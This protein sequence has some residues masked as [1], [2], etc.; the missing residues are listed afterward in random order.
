VVPGIL[1]AGLVIG[2]LAGLGADLGRPAVARIQL[3]GASDRAAE[4]AERDLVRRG[5][6]DSMRAAQA[7]ADGQHADL[8]RFEIEPS[9]RVA[10]ALSRH[11]E[12][13]VLGGVDA[14]SGWYDVET[15]ARSPGPLGG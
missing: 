13:L 6:Q 12:P 11:V 2:L 9:G 8:A 15:S 7:V 3:Q 1:K 5:P 4:N 10:V 14:L